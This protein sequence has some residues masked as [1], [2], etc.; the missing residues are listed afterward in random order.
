M[1]LQIWDVNPRGQGRT[2]LDL[3]AN[4][5]VLSDLQCSNRVDARV[6]HC[7]DLLSFLEANPH[8]ARGGGRASAAPCLPICPV[9]H[10]L[11]QSFIQGDCEL[12][13]RHHSFPLVP[14]LVCWAFM[15]FVG[16]FSF[17]L[18]SLWHASVC[19]IHDSAVHL[20]ENI[21]LCI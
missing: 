13:R 9:P 19:I 16:F 4:T 15:F 7:I 2:L 3:D 20:S 8:S 17:L 1:T 14:A 12:T 11:T 21:Y 6:W 10:I 5:V 18:S